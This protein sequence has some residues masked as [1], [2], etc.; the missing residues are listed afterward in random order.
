[1]ERVKN[2]FQSLC[3]HNTAEPN[4]KQITVKTTMPMPKLFTVQRGEYDTRVRKGNEV[5]V[6]DA[7]K[8]IYGTKILPLEKHYN[9]ED[10]FSPPLEPAYFE[11]KPLVLLFGEYSTGKTSFIKYILGKEYPGMRIGPEPTTENFIVVEY[12]DEE[13]IIPGNALVV[14]KSKQYGTLAKFG[15]QFLNRFQCSTVNCGLLSKV[16]LV[17]TPGILSGEKD[18]GYDITAVL[19]YLLPFFLYDEWFAERCDRIILLFDINKLDI[20]DELRTAID[21]VKGYEDKIKIV[22]NKSDTVTTQQLMRVYGALMW[23]LGKVLATPEAAR[24]YIGS[25]WA[26]PWGHEENRHLFEE[27]EADLVID[28]YSLSRDADLRKL[29]DLVRRAKNVKIHAYIMAELRKHMPLFGVG[30]ERRKK[31]LIYELTEIYER[32]AAQHQIPPG[33]FPSMNEL[34]KKLLAFDFNKIKSR[35]KKLF[36]QVE[37]VLNQDIGRLVTLLPG[38][39]KE[40]LDAKKEQRKHILNK[41]KSISSAGDEDIPAEPAADQVIVDTTKKP[42]TKCKKRGKKTLQKTGTTP[43]LTDSESPISNNLGPGKGSEKISQ[44]ASEES[45]EKASEKPTGVPSDAAPTTA[46]NALHAAT[47][48]PKS[49]LKNLKP[50]IMSIRGTVK[51]A[52]LKKHY[53]LKAFSRI[54]LR[55][56]T[57]L[58]RASSPVEQNAFL[59]FWF[60]MRSRVV[61]LGIARSLNLEVCTSLKKQIVNSTY[62]TPHTFPRSRVSFPNESQFCPKTLL[63]LIASYFHCLSSQVWNEKLLSRRVVRPPGMPV[64]TVSNAK[65]SDTTGA[66][67]VGD[68][69]THTRY[70]TISSRTTSLRTPVVITREGPNSGDSSFGSGSGAVR[71]SSEAGTVKRMAPS[72]HL[73]TRTIVTRTESTTLSPSGDKVVRTETTVATPEKTEVKTTETTVVDGRTEVKESSQLRPADTYLTSY[74]EYQAPRAEA[75]YATIQKK[76][77]NT[78]PKVEEKKFETGGDVPTKATEKRDEGAAPPNAKRADWPTTARTEV[79]AEVAEPGKGDTLMKIGETKKETTEVKVQEKTTIIATTTSKPANGGVKLNGPVKPNEIKSTLPLNIQEPPAEEKEDKILNVGTPADSAIAVTMS[80]T[81]AAVE[82]V[83]HAG[84][85]NESREEQRR[86]FLFGV[87]SN[88][89]RQKSEPSVILKEMKESYDQS[90]IKDYDEIINDS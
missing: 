66:E 33:D 76:K 1:M 15:A 72:P 62:Q 73:G 52:S 39:D 20:S 26:N 88:E 48:A 8:Q 71:S 2:F 83:T 47:S 70:Q 12:G 32:L 40:D 11:S 45:R 6:A 90:S 77:E 86:K 68:P 69:Q 19:R 34:K 14:D 9:F 74:N 24:V 84:S 31:K 5:V 38:Q 78:P 87:A 59:K 30:L 58:N 28:I 22:L 54:I 21:M 13:G 43:K 17:D 42:G 49:S 67:A 53:S 81:A 82:H 60:F 57:N 41:V 29:N 56:Y 44:E 65:L 80:D 85:S 63:P 35:K 25:F 23:S 61:N 51:V 55:R 46:S 75:L 37:E 7:L 10:F 18:R 64:Y 27:E 36:E 89:Q 50:P 3:G 16:T 4:I 79:A